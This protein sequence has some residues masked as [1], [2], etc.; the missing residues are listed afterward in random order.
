[1]VLICFFVDIVVCDGLMNMREVVSTVDA[2]AISR[3]CGF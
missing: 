1:M 3:W 2:C